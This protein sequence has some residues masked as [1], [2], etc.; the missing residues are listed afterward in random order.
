MRR[1]AAALVTAGGV[2]FGGSCFW[3]PSG[4]LFSVRDYS[5]SE[6]V[7][8]DSGEPIATLIEPIAYVSHGRLSAIPDAAAPKDFETAWYKGHGRYAL[9]AGGRA[10]G[11]LEITGAAF[12]IQCES[13]DAVGKVTPPGLVSGMRMGL[14]SDLRF[15]DPGYRRRAPTGPERA[16]MRAMADTLYLARGVPREATRTVR[17][18]NMT[19]FDGRMGPVLVGSFVIRGSG[20]PGDT[21]ADRIR[22]AFLIAERDG[23]GHWR[24]TFNWFN[25]GEETS[26]ATQDLVDLL[27]IDGDGAPELITQWGLYEV[28]SHITS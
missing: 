24:P 10:S 1:A 16:A 5:H 3:A 17:A 19:A 22:A 9:Y 20:A 27:D 14:A 11:T 6:T 23:A 18:S 13:L 21:S 26:I 8:S 7:A 15:R 12:K 4:V 25:D 2:L 28:P